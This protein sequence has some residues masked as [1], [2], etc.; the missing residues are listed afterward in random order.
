MN[1][2]LLN[3]YFSSVWKPSTSGFGESGFDLAKEIADDEWV[4]DVGCGYHPYKNLIKNIVVLILLMMPQTIKCVSKTL[5]LIN[6]LML[7]FV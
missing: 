6:V 5:K 1:Q 7:H 2:E 3:K 4:L